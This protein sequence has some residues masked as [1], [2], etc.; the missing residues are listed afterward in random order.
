[1]DR[2]AQIQR[3]SVSPATSGDS[4]LTCTVRQSLA[5]VPGGEL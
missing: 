1:M 5:D 3:T 4:V 2:F